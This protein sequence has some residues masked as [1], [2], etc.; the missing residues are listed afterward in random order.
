MSNFWP[1]GLDLSD[2]QSPKEILKVAQED[3]HQKSEGKMELV[4]Q[5]TTST[6]GQ[7]MVVV[8]AKHVASDRTSTLFSI[9]HRPDNNPYPVRIQLEKD[10]LPDSLKKTYERSNSIG[11]MVSLMAESTYTVSNP[12]VSDTPAEFRKKLVEAFNTSSIKGV[13]INL[14][15]DV[16][17]DKNGDQQ[18]DPKE[19]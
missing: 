11:N 13:I 3:W 5:D 12:W 8:H 9:V 10:N 7:I 4:L 2:T 14:A 6:T 16:S 17:N 15:S 19:S 18:D 1:S